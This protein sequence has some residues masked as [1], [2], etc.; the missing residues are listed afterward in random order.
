MQKL[1]NQKIS[2]DIKRYEKSFLKITR[3]DIKFN[4]RIHFRLKK[5]EEHEIIAWFN[6]DKDIVDGD[7]FKCIRS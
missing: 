4:S 5:H 1:E 7:K 6:N 3:E 2:K